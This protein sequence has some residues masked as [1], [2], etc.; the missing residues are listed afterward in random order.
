MPRSVFHSMLVMLCGVSAA[1]SIRADDTP[2]LVTELHWGEHHEAPHI[3]TGTGQQIIIS[4]HSEQLEQYS[5]MTWDNSSRTLQPL[6]PR[7]SAWSPRPQAVKIGDRLFVLAG[8]SVM[9]D[10]VALWEVGGGSPLEMREICVLGP[11]KSTLAAFPSPDANYAILALQEGGE[12]GLG[13]L[14]LWRTDGTARGTVCLGRDGE[15]YL[16]PHSRPTALD[17]ERWAIFSHRR[18]P[19]NVYES[20]AWISDG[21]PEDTSFV[22]LPQMSDYPGGAKDRSASLGGSILIAPLRYHA[23]AIELWRTDCTPEGTRE[24]TTIRWKGRQAVEAR[25][26]TMG[27]HAYVLLV[28]S[29]HGW[30]LW[31][32][33]GTENG[34]V[35]VKS[36]E[37]YKNSPFSFPQNSSRPAMAAVGGR[38]VF[39]VDDGDHGEEPWVTDGTTEGTRLLKDCNPGPDD[40]KFAKVTQRDGKVIFWSHTKDF[41][42]RP[43]MELWSTD[44]T[45]SGTRRL[46]QMQSDQWRRCSAE[47]TSVIAG[48]YVYF[49]CFDGKHGPSVWSLRLSAAP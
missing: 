34:T 22:P 36:M 29:M 41:V 31:Q 2:A 14:T 46:A 18:A 25:L 17:K 49:E 3:I 42:D 43:W 30:D 35:L 38:L 20:G 37:A 32:T 28:D 7:H 1:G 4:T 8:S 13:Q 9:Q 45:E 48:G 27:D 16:G 19:T 11:A 21:T 39:V 12:R 40:C 24:V 6:L 15:H 5:L 23:S 44:G 33:D 26:C 47:T 10:L